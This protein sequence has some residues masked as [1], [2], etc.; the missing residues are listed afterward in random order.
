M[1]L[2]AP[3]PPLNPTREMF[4]PYRD[5]EIPRPRM[6]TEEEWR[7]KPDLLA[8]MMRGQGDREDEY[9]I[10]YRRHFYAMVTGV[11]LAVGHLLETLRGHDILDDTLIVFASDHGD[12]CGDHRMLS[13]HPSF[14]DEL[15]H[16]PALFHWPAGLGTQ[17]RDISGL[18]EMVDLLP[19]ML[20]LCSLRPPRAMAGRSYAQALLSGE[21]P[22]THPD[23]MAYFGHGHAM[24]RT[25]THKLI[26]YNTDEDE[27][28]YDL[29]SDPHET[30]NRADDPKCREMLHEM[31]LRML[32]R[33]LECSASAL[34]FLGRY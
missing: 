33:S 24:L 12:M 27:I 13:K 28:L 25:E 9:Y 26:R 29:Q 23:A 19:T 6:D 18:I 2:Y 10:N 15:M 21:Q 11:D 32:R 30:T 4:A 14:Y 20:E 16:L 3:H 34:P 1:G 5:A 8:R 31:R 22:E 17:R 7:D